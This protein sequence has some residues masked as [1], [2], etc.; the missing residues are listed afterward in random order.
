MSHAIAVVLFKLCTRVGAQFP[1]RRML[2]RVQ[3]RI[4]ARVVIT[5]PPGT[6]IELPVNSMLGPTLKIGK[7]SA[8]TGSTLPTARIVTDPKRFN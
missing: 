7:P 1:G 5:M 8:G 4:L 2:D 3:Q 6:V